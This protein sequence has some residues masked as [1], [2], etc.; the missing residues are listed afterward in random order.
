MFDLPSNI[1]LQRLGRSGDLIICS[2]DS[3]SVCFGTFVAKPLHEYWIHSLA[4]SSSFSLRSLS[5]EKAVRH[6]RPYE[7]KKANRAGKGINLGNHWTGCMTE[8]TCRPRRL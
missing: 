2:A 5:A 4:K 8:M 6:A 1:L 7:E 3:R